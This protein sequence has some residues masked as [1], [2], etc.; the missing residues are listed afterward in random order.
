MPDAYGAVRVAGDQATVAHVDDRVGADHLA[1][2]GV[3]HLERV[4]VEHGAVARAHLPDLDARVGRSARQEAAVA[5]SRQ[6]RDPVDVRRGDAHAV[7]AAA[8]VHVPHAQFALIGAGDEHEASV[9]VDRL[10]RVHVL[11]LVGG[12]RS[13]VRSGAA[14]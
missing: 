14:R 11:H 13:E 2:G 1:C 7:A 8:V 10:Q 6:A 4:H 9:V 12:E 3:E 5:R